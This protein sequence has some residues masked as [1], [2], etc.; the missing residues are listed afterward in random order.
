M[1]VINLRFPC[2]R[3]GALTDH[4]AEVCLPGGQRLATVYGKLLTAVPCP[5]C[6][7][8]RSAIDVARQIL[9]DPLLRE[10]WL[11]PGQVAP[12]PRRRAA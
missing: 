2:A 6:L 11:R 5:R 3:F 1:F 8:R 4:F 12:P 10:D 7:A 9:N